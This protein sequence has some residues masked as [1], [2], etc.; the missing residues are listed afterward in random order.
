MCG[1]VKIHTS[2]WR[3]ESCG[4]RKSKDSASPRVTTTTINRW[5]LSMHAASD[6]FIGCLPAHGKCCTR[7]LVHMHVHGLLVVGER[8]KMTPFY[9]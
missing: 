6:P 8:H 3:N 2:T 4:A 1:I 5:L 9:I 7:P